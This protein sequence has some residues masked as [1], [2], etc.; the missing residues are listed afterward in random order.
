MHARESWLGGAY[1]R[2]YDGLCGYHPNRRPWHFQWSATYYLNRHLRQVLSPLGGIVLDVGCRDKPYRGWFGAVT[3]YV[4]LDAVAGASTDVIVMPDELWPLPN[5][6]FDVLLSTQV[7]E[8][9]EHPDF[10]LAE[11]S[12]VLKPGGVVVMSFPFLYNEHG[13]HDMQ[14]FTAHRA[15][16]LFPDFEVV[17]L[18]RQGGIGSTLAILS[19]NWAEQTMN[20]RFFTRI[21]K[22]LLLPVWLAVSVIF[23]FVGLLIDRI[24]RTGSFYS[25]VLLVVR[26]R[27]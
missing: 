1:R 4:G 12:R 18:E 5:E 19:L 9:V 21:L 15:V 17:R 11:M 26:K 22:S 27:S 23:N 14:R 2:I 8:Y 24:D 3:E 7:L 20:R 16:S 13:E 6:H 10:M 25:N